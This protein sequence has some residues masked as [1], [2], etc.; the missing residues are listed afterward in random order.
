MKRFEQ[1]VALVTGS[2]RGIGAATAVELAREGASVVVVA[3]STNERP[4]PDYPGTL[5]STV[6]EIEQLGVT[7][8][9]IQADI[10]NG[11]DLERIHRETMAKF[12]R[13]DILVHN[14]AVQFLGPY[15]DLSVR[16]WAKLMAINV[17][18]PFVLTQLFL[19]S[20]LANRSGR[21][22]NI[23]SGA[24][25]ID[26]NPAQARA[27]WGEEAVQRERGDRRL[28]YGSSKAWLNRF[29]K[30]VALET[31]GTGVTCN[32]LEVIAVSPVFR[33]MAAGIDLSAF[34]L[35]EAPAQL[36]AWLAAQPDDVSGEIFVQDELLPELRAAGA[37]R[38]KVDPS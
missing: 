36:V 16:Q 12:G 28:A 17:R 25:R 13:C 4:D 22:I 20:M 38:P 6:D 11:D 27:G 18:A 29:T 33:K 32:A 1:K 8:L 26:F 21:I 35:P 15:L 30:G 37:V 34:E 14:A 7:A 3:R 5:E 24:G 10:S 31:T 9:A 2:S 23:S 19:P